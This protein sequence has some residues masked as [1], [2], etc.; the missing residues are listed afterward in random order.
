VRKNR[1]SLNVNVISC[2]YYDA[3]LKTATDRHPPYGGMRK[4]M[5]DGRMVPCHSNTNIRRATVVRTSMSCTCWCLLNKN[6]DASRQCGE[7]SQRCLTKQDGWRYTYNEIM[8]DRT[9]RTQHR[10][11]LR[12]AFTREGRSTLFSVPRPAAHRACI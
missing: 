12:A 9:T 11:N 2:K 4:M 5:Q 7:C 3:D 1:R 10:R 8:S 6:F